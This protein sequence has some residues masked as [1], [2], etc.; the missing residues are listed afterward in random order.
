MVPAEYVVHTLHAC[1]LYVNR[2]DADKS[3]TNSLFSFPRYAHP[4]TPQSHLRRIRDNIRPTAADRPGTHDRAHRTGGRQP[5]G[6]RCL[7]NSTG[8]TTMPPELNRARATHVNISRHSSG[9]HD[10]TATR[11]HKTRSIPDEFSSRISTPTTATK[12]RLATRRRQAHRALQIRRLRK[13]RTPSS[14]LKHENG[15]DYDTAQLWP[16]DDP[17]LRVTFSNY[18]PYTCITS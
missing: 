3:R 18:L 13:P 16:S 15:M 1:S 14:G 17:F 7:R 2:I 10:T 6:R 4:T 9:D 5:D 11:R 12:P 8:R